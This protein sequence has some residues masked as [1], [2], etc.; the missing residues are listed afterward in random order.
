MKLLSIATALLILLCS[1]CLSRKAENNQ[2]VVKTEQQH[3]SIKGIDSLSFTVDASNYSAKIF[4]QTAGNMTGFFFQITKNDSVISDQQILKDEF[5]YVKALNRIERIQIRKKEYLF[6]ILREKQQGN[7]AALVTDLG[8][9]LYNIKVG[10]LTKLIYG[11]LDLVDTD[12]VAGQIE[13][14]ESVPKDSAVAKFIFRKMIGNNSF[15]CV[16][17]S[18]FS[19]LID[20]LHLYFTDDRVCQITEEGLVFEVNCSNSEIDSSWLEITQ[21]PDKPGDFYFPRSC[22]TSY[23]IGATAIT[24]IEYPGYIGET[25]F[26]S[27]RKK[28]NIDSSKISYVLGEVTLSRFDG[29]QQVMEL[30]WPNR[31]KVYVVPS[32]LRSNFKT[33]DDSECKD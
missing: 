21:D 26:E 4:M 2:E 13:N 1:G 10:S 19:K 9:Y 3:V 23:V 30:S 14:P 32:S 16:G 33:R 11:G 5:Y 7:G 15:A 22:P 25:K 28:I 27:F 12:Q 20:D 17:T 31:D 18:P 29:Y 24:R 6:F 8:I